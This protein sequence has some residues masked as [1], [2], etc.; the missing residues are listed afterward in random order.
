ML[1]LSSSS[2]FGSADDIHLQHTVVVCNSQ[3]SLP[4][5]ITV[6]SALASPN[7]QKTLSTNLR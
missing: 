5:A 2:G 4:N 7:P 6:D 3:V 1:L